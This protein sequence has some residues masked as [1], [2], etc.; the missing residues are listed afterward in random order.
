MFSEA[1]ANVSHGCGSLHPEPQGRIMTSH[2]GSPDRTA[3]SFEQM[4]SHAR[5]ARS[6]LIL[7]AQMLQGPVESAGPLRLPASPA[8]VTGACGMRA[9]CRARAV[10][11]TK[12]AKPP[13]INF[14][15]AL[16]S[17]WCASGD[18]CITTPG[19]PMRH[20]LTHPSLVDRASCCQDMQLQSMKRRQCQVQHRCD[21]AI[22]RHYAKKIC[23]FGRVVCL[24]RGNVGFAVA[25]S[26][27]LYF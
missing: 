8:G 19:I 21:E 16:I 18:F 23:E 2:A 25:T 20:V 3:P 11:L 26:L 6:P 4:I 15:H 7:E 12:T 13:S 14:G 5:R 1:T 9:P 27:E 24:G 10:E 22:N 17:G